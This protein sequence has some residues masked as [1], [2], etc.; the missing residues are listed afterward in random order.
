[1]W[2]I[3]LLLLVHL[4]LWPWPSYIPILIV[5]AL[6]AGLGLWWAYPKVDGVES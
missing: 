2:L 3:P 4:L 6:L 1:L 5:L